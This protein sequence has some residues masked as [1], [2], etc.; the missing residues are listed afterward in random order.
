[1][2]INFT[3]SARLLVVPL[4]LL[5]LWQG[6]T[7]SGIISSGVLASPLD[8]L[9]VGVEL[10][11]DGRLQD[12][13]IVSLGRA[14]SGLVLGVVTGVVLG[15]LAGFWKAG[16]GLIDANMQMLRTVPFVALAPVFIVWFGI[17]EAAKTAL[18]VFATTFPVYINT[19]AGIRDVDKRLLEVARTTGLGTW[20]VIREIV[21]PGALPFILVGFRYAM[22]LSVIS[23]VVAEQIN[24]SGGIGELMFDARRFVQTDVIALCLVLYAVLGL[25]ANCFARWLEKVLLAW[26]KEVLPV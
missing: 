15:V 16:E 20:G 22:A 13:L 14:L 12:A 25:L 5:V 18:V 9:R 7:A 19:Y 8:T 4:V 26:R 23:L 11:G 17:D 24:V 10:F 2:E 21:L 3:K 1:M 6:L